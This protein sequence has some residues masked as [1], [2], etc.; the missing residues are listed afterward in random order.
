MTSEAAGYCGVGEGDVGCVGCSDTSGVAAGEGAA[1]DGDAV[2][3]FSF[4]EEGAC[5]N[6]SKE[7]LTALDEGVAGG[8]GP[9]SAFV[10]V[11]LSSGGV[12]SM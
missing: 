9:A 6:E 12:A 4:S 3:E 1:G 10:G 11:G 7:S 5:I 2:G 8:V